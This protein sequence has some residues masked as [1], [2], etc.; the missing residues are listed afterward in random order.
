MVDTHDYDVLSPHPYTRTRRPGP[1][2]VDTRPRGLTHVDGRSEL[3]QSG[4]YPRGYRRNDSHSRPA[5]APTPAPQPKPLTPAQRAIARL[6]A[7]LEIQQIQFAAE[8]EHIRQTWLAALDQLISSIES[9]IRPGV[10]SAAS[11][12]AP[13][14]KKPK[15]QQRSNSSKRATGRSPRTN[16]DK[17]TARRTYDE[18]LKTRRTAR[19]GTPPAAAAASNTAMRRTDPLAEEYRR[20]SG[21][22]LN[23]QASGHPV[24]PDVIAHRDRLLGEYRRRARKEGR[25][26]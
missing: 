14:S 20:V 22:I 8:T 16:Q 13:K 11:L 9:T 26:A 3:L 15:R 10:K 2:F 4:V 7:E 12:P 18:W 24:S 25:V 17:T 1:V 19:T 6:D 21:A 23:L 5:D